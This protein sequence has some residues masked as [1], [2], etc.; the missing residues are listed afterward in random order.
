MRAACVRAGRDPAS[1][2]LVAVTKGRDPA[3]MREAIA[4]G[5]RD[6]GEN[7]VREALEKYAVFCPGAAVEQGK[8]RLRW[9]GI[10][11][12]QTNK[13]KDAVRIFDVIHS[14]D[15][16]RLAEKI[17]EQA[18]EVSK[19][20]DVLL[21]INVSGERSKYGFRPEESLDA[22]ISAL[23]FGNLKILGFMTVGPKESDPE[24][25]RKHFRL[26]RKLFEQARKN[27]I[28]VK[29]EA[30]D[31][32]REVSMGMSDDFEVAL[33]EGSTVVRVGRAIF[34]KGQ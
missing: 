22:L 31:A 10:G 24:N 19:I 34:D 23:C 21:E 29:P 17:S 11:H 3:V 28:T 14:V 16:L 15:S 13:V 26:L 5:V 8:C 6:I 4:A 12:V 33:E 20:Q 18:A 27:L 32:F 7:R 25:V 2:T 30:A 9:H 1:V